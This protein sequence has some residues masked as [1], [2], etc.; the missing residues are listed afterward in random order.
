MF[1]ALWVSFPVV[2]SGSEVGSPTPG[3]ASL[4][5]VLFLDAQVGKNPPRSV[6]VRC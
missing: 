5:E 2:V 3:A 4:I 1:I 6:G